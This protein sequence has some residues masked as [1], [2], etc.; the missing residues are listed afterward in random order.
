MHL[1]ILALGLTCILQGLICE[2][3]TDLPKGIS[4]VIAMIG[5][6]ICTVYVLD[7]IGYARWLRLVS[8]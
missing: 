1:F 8:L 5:S 7:L 6:G 2:T 4:R 3:N